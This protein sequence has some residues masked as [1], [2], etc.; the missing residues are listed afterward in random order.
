MKRQYTF[1]LALC[2][3]FNTIAQKVVPMEIKDNGAVGQKKLKKAPKKVYIA[4]F[5]VFYQMLYTQSEQTR[6]GVNHGATSASIAVGLSGIEE[7]HLQQTTN[8]IYAN[9]T[10]KLK[11]EGFEIVGADEA[12]NIKYY[13]DWERKQGGTLSRAQF[14]G[15]VMSTPE[16]YEY[17]VKGT[18][19][20]GKE[21]VTFTDKTY[22]VGFELGKITAISVNITIPFMTDAESAGSKMLTSA[23]GG[24]SKIV[25]KPDLRIGNEIVGGSINNA[26]TSA[27]YV[28]TEQKIAADCYYPLQLKDPIKIDGVLSG[29]KMKTIASAEQKTAMNMGAMTLVYDND[30]SI[31]NL[32]MVSCEPEK[33]TKGVEDA[34]NV[35]LNESL[36]LFFTYQKGEKPGK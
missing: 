16:G 25:V 34:S 18:K 35:F 1:I 8:N 13:E 29:E 32:Q 22:K 3:G 21:K 24:I 17:F 7:E 19:N 11:A 33:Y 31:S 28:F 6:E 36:D 2:I 5:R 4:E 9:Y 27:N 12:A 14:P 23:V 30:V 10:K 26:V 15:F 20:S